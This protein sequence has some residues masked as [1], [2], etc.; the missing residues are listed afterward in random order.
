MYNK[1][2]LFFGK[3][4]HVGA[5]KKT[6]AIPFP[7]IFFYLSFS[8]VTP[9]KQDI[10]RNNH[11]FVLFTLQRKNL[12]EFLYLTSNR[13]YSLCNLKLLNSESI[14]PMWVNLKNNRIDKRR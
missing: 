10:K 3:G 1:E 8:L 13:G 7:I 12:Y 4:K 6:Y 11:I 9:N 5:T 2:E 14:T